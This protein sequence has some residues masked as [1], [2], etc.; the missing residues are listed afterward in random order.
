MVVIFSFLSFLCYYGVV[1]CCLL[2]SRGYDVVA[3]CCLF[4]ALV[5]LCSVM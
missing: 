3:M 5:L 4:R 2:G 1:M